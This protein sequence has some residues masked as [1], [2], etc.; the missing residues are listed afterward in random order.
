MAENSI[1]CISARPRPTTQA[2]RNQ[3]LETLFR[4]KIE[5][6]QK[7]R[8]FR[9]PQKNGGSHFLTFFEPPPTPPPQKSGFQVGGGGAS[10]GSFPKTHW[11]M[12]LWDKIMILPCV[13][14][15][16]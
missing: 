8:D 15:T 9:P 13:K 3:D 10:R 12:H 1:K 14:P 6:H 16:I 2:Q 4:L 7:I 11:E 5:K